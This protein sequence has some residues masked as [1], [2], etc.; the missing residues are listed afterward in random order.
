MAN[1]KFL[2]FA[3]FV[4]IFAFQSALTM[5]DYDEINVYNKYSADQVNKKILSSR[6]NFLI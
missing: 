1:A 4:I 3:I 5:M 6:N 2:V